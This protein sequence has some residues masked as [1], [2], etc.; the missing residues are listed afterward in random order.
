VADIQGRLDDVF[1]YGGLRV[2]PHVFRSA[3]GRHTGVLEYQVRQTTAGARIAVR[4]CGPV[5][6]DRLG[7]EVANGLAAVGLSRPSIEIRTVERLERDPGPAKLRRFVPL[8]REPRGLV[9]PVLA[10]AG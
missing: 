1:L 2:H 8:G 10:A 7:R 4:C 9:D 5:D 6:L 3:L